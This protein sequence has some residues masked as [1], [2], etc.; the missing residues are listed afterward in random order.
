LDG[1]LSVMG[2]QKIIENQAITEFKQLLLRVCDCEKANCIQL[3]IRYYYTRLARFNNWKLNV[4]TLSYELE[5]Q[6]QLDIIKLK[7]MTHNQLDDYASQWLE[8]LQALDEF[9]LE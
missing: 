9:Y 8:R 3:L 7:D 1:A 2:F 4:T 5:F 6:M